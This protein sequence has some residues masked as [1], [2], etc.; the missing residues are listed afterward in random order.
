V[1]ANALHFESPAQFRRWLEKNHATA[2]EL[3]VLF[4]KKASGRGGVT[5]PQALDEALC[6]GW[7]DGVRKRVDDDSYT[8][9]FTPR[10]AGSIWSRI[11]IGHVKRL[12]AAGKMRPAGQTAFAAR[13]EKKSGVYS[14]EQRPQ[15][16]PSKYRQTFKLNRKAWA[17]WEQQPP[18]YR[19]IVT[20]WVVSAKQEATR[21]RRLT[22][23]I[24][25]CAAGRRVG[26]L[27]P[28]KK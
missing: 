1:R 24:A 20:W 22:R 4:F 9:R 8:I 27:E 23:L 15:E 21:E 26:I 19:R 6:F 18:G 5:Y 13:D 10:R 25:D 14:F 2:D 12:E 3:L 11:N 17:Y 7:I 16:L 28:R